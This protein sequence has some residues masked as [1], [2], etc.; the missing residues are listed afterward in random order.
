[1]KNHRDLQLGVLIERVGSLAGA[2]HLQGS[3][4][5]V[6][7]WALWRQKLRVEH[8]G[9]SPPDIAAKAWPSDLSAMLVQRV[10][11]KLPQG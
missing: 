4:A 3:I 2:V 10:T 9:K 11:E 1:M 5:G 6:L 7:R 8:K